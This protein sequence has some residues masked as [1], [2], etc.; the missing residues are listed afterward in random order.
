MGEMN[1]PGESFVLSFE[2]KRTCFD[3]ELLELF[4]FF[5]FGTSRVL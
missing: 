3:C 1:E 5:F 4:F 2:T